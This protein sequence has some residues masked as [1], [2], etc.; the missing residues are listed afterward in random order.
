MPVP[1]LGVS[2]PV[3]D[4]E[5]FDVDDFYVGPA[6]IDSD[7]SIEDDVPETSDS[8]KHSREPQPR[9]T[10][11]WTNS[12]G[13][14][15]DDRYEMK[16]H[17][18]S[19]A[20]ITDYVALGAI[21]LIRLVQHVDNSGWVM[22]GPRRETMYPNP[23]ISLGEKRHW[24]R[25]QLYCHTNDTRRACLRVYA[26]PED[27]KRGSRGS[28]KDL[29]KVLKLVTEFVDT[30]TEAWEGT[31]DPDTP[32]RTY[33][34]PPT[35]QEESL[36]YIF[37]TLSSPQPSMDGAGTCHFSHQSMVAIFEDAIDGLKTPL[38]PYQ[39]RS[40]ATM[41]QKEAN[42]AKL[43]D[44][45]KLRFHDIHGK[46]FYFDALEG[47]LCLRPHLY[48][49][50]CGGILAETMGY[51]KTLICIALILATRGHYPKLPEGRI[52]TLAKTTS[53]R[54]PSL[55][56]LTAKKLK[57]AGVPW[58]SHFASLQREG[59]HVPH[60]TEAIERFDAEFAEPIF[61]PI[62]PSRKLKTRE[63]FRVLRLC[64][65]TLLIVPPNLLVQWQ[66]EIEKHTEERCLD[67]LVL[68]ST[69]KDI[70]SYKTL[71]KYDVVLITKARF[72]QEYR[73]DDLHQGKRMRG[74]E[75]FRSPLTEVRW[76]RV[77]CDEGHGF[78]G[79]SYKTHAMAMLDKMSV[80]RRWVV[81]GTP[82]Q[83]LHGVE[84]NLALDEH[85]PDGGW[86]RRES[87]QT[88]LKQRKTKD[89]DLEEIKDLERLRVMVVKFLKLQPW[90]N[91]KGDD[92]ADWKKYLSPLDGAGTR[93]FAPA[94]RGVLQSLI[95]RHRIE[96]IDMD[97]C[98]PPLHNR[99]VFLDPSYYDKISM[100]LFRMS[101]SAN[102][103]T[104]ER[105]DEDYMFHPRNRKSLDDLVSN[106]RHASFHWVGWTHHEVTET[107]RVS[108]TY[109]D[110]NI[111]NISDDDGRL[112]TEAIMNGDRALK[113][114]GWCALSFFHEMGV[115]VKGFPDHAAP[116]WALSGKTTTPLLL[117]TVQAREA[118]QYVLKNLESP[119]PADGLTGAGLRAMLASRDRA[120]QEEQARQKAA[121]TSN[122]KSLTAG[123]NE[124]PKVKNQST[125]SS[126]SPMAPLRS[127]SKGAAPEFLTSANKRPRSTSFT[128]IPAHLTEATIIG[129]ISAKLN[130]LCSRILS[131][132]ETE[133]III[134]YDSN[135]IAFWIA[136]ALELLSVKFL[137]YANTLS[138]GRRAAYL[139]T[140]N[141]SEAF[142]VLL[143]DLKQA[144][145]GLHVASA[146][147][148][149]I[150]S[151][152]WQPSIESQAIKRAHRIGQ[153]KPVYVET[154]VL[155][156]TLEQKILKRRRQMSNAELVKAEKS[157]LD[158]G[159]MNGI[160]RAEGFLNIADGEDKQL[161][162][163]KLDSP[164]PLFVRS[165]LRDAQTQADDDLILALEPEQ[166]AKKVKKGK[167]K[168]MTV[169]L[170][171]RENVATLR[172]ASPTT[173][174]VGGHQSIFGGGS[175][176]PNDR[177]QKSV[178]ISVEI[179][180][181]A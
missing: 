111:D 78:A 62:T 136:E 131:L 169:A 33:A 110:N 128:A 35:S 134:F 122:G 19:D 79:S 119:D 67:I 103:V 38:Y 94:L 31:Y 118:Q 8:E 2:Q 120:T 80:E 50:S 56:E 97:L 59:Y 53:Q 5:R 100:N 155:K 95:I 39:K 16:D 112:L 145:H 129:F 96:D 158:D 99:T 93:R 10:H 102:A 54:T 138:V 139:A 168:A 149:F 44:P 148:V 76:L 178:R 105:V 36:F 151:P 40:V 90:A 88:A 162:G 75:K 46:D 107:L 1:N 6:S 116:A 91:Q 132:Q 176:N 166:F 29:R 21:R 48:S 43:L 18:R 144:S 154:L 121:A 127:S 57:H 30:S 83:S 9:L 179:P 173:P 24:L 153:T 69:T 170:S 68:D 49:E 117:G 108:N 163:G 14:Q 165:H 104:S 141:Q 25:I 34:E 146:S 140:F 60:L 12:K 135:N 115:Y 17:Q 72:D 171:A 51:G 175:D 160:I 159:T 143:M 126:T 52:D 89:P 84:V 26:L 42:P 142:R 82:S 58:K 27:V 106:L 101:L 152:I 63:D 109:L 167:Q 77:I 55:L 73:D 20:N 130:Y 32:I 98:L 180:G 161:I 124:Q 7:S 3:D 113:D 86:S 177:P 172:A 23:L 70:P 11:F 41:L 123:A 133:K 4:G 66:H 71:M 74:Q 125:F 114:P 64:Y 156:G 47:S 45:R 28:I 85:I 157:L 13:L 174:T 15:M 137:I 37:N 65:A 181:S 22:L 87:I 61:H 92:Y 164:I 81:S 150:V 147:R